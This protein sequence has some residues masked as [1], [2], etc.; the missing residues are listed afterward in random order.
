MRNS[1]FIT[2]EERTLRGRIL[3]L[4]DRE[5][6]YGYIIIK[7][8]GNKHKSAIYAALHSLEKEGITR[9]SDK[10]NNRITYFLTDTGKDML[11]LIKDLKKTSNDMALKEVMKDLKLRTREGLFDKHDSQIV[12]LAIRLKIVD[13]EVFELIKPYTPSPDKTRRYTKIPNVGLKLIKRGKY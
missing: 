7:R 12:A 3:E 2:D 11:K 1:N 10:K 5:I 13:K 6:N 4:I 8:L 9:I